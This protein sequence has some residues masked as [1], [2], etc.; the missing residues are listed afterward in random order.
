M[1]KL[2][3]LET[4]YEVWDDNHG[5]VIRVG[6]DHDGCNLVEVREYGDDAV[7]MLRELV[8][9]LDQAELVAKAILQC[10][11]DLRAQTLAKPGE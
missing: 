2:F 1:S 6:P 3:S 4:R 10:V 9:T 11:A 5:N 8:L 7:T